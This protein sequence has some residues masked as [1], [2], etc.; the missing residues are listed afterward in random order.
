ML[1]MLTMIAASPSKVRSSVPKECE[2]L[3]AI[4][5]DLIENLFDNECGDAV[6]VLSPYYE[7][8]SKDR[9]GSWCSASRIP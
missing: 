9:K 1:N 3:E 2:F 6:S 5:T 8:L 4:K 7:H